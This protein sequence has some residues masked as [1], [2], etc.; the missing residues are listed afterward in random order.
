MTWRLLCGLL[1]AGVAALVLW[2][3]TDSA[4]SAGAARRI[5]QAVLRDAPEAAPPTAAPDDPPTALPF[6]LHAPPGT[7][8]RPVWVGMRIMLASAP[9]GFQGVLLPYL[10]GGGQVWLDGVLLGDI[11]VSS[12]AVHVRWERPHL[13]VVPPG[14]LHAGV[15]E[16]WVH[17]V[18]VSGET[19]L[20]FP[21]LEV[22]ALA[23]L[24]VR[25]DRRFF[26]VHTM[27]DLTVGGCLVVAAFVLLIW[28]RL[29]EEVLYGWFGV[30]TLLWG[31]RTLTFVMESVPPERW[32]WWRLVYLA[33]TGGFIIVMALFAARLSGLRSRLAERGLLVYWLLGPAWF[34]LQGLGSDAQVNRL[35][36][37][38]LIPIGLATV[39]VSFV[40][41]WRQRTLASLWLPLALAVATLSGVHDYLVVWRPEALERVAPGWVGQRLFLLHHGANFLLLA[42]GVLLS[43]RFVRSVRSLR[44]LNETLET[45][46]TDRERALAGNFARLA[47]LERRNAA[48]EER[49]LIMREIHDGLGSK[50]FTSLSRVERGAMDKDG[51]AAALRACISDMRLALDALAP[52]DHD[53]LTAFGDFMFRWQ[54]ELQSAGVRCD[55][56]MDVQA[57]ELPLPPHATLQVLRVAQ[58]ALTNVA[59]HSRATRVELVL[60]EHDGRLALRVRDDGT[61][62]PVAPAAGGR[63]LGNMRARAEQLG[64]TLT[65]TSAE[66][67]GT[68][69]EL[70]VPLDAVLAEG[71]RAG[72]TPGR[73]AEGPAAA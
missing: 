21:A 60:A 10:Y 28:W 49:K 36:T 50:L 43:T 33:S 62:M 23:A 71:R 65:V 24:Q 27:P 14:R 67:G 44:D 22:G 48:S 68:V 45:R 29:P 5:T 63:G 40:A 39:V 46:I 69:V 56:T 73:I 38:G 4:P 3:T 16:L 1:F 19:A 64:A 51:M 59:K 37:A 52:D 7:S 9:E 31:L 11:P 66:D 41:V 70:V 72:D 20:N 54:A 35:W 30:A 17:A 8:P 18:P 53:L 61:G 26:W 47:E 57:D 34:L 42:M 6:T 13:L 25:H 12:A 2:L 58:E 15:N 32:A 55:W